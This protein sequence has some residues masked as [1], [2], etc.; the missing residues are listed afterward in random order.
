MK[1]ME[2]YGKVKWLEGA[3]EYIGSAEDIDES[4][5]KAIDEILEYVRNS[6]I[7]ENESEKSPSY[8]VET[9]LLKGEQ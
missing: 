7:K 2:I 4:I 8:T 5:F 3:L 1:K 6:E 9:T